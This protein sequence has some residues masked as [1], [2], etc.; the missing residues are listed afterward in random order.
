VGLSSVPRVHA[1]GLE[2]QGLIVGFDRN[3][4]VK[5]VAPRGSIIGKRYPIPTKTTPAQIDRALADIFSILINGGRELGGVYLLK[6]SLYVEVS[7]T[8]FLE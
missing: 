2:K 1:K 6:L 8:Q 3:S 7:I 4:L 5:A